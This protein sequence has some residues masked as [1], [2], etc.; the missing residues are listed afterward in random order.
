MREFFE[1]WKPSRKS[2]WLIIQINEILDDYES[3][4]YQLTLR[5]LYYQLVSRDLGVAVKQVVKLW[6]REEISGENRDKIIG[7]LLEK[8][9]EEEIRNRV[10]NFL[11][12]ET[13]KTVNAILEEAINR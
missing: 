9:V 4:G 1:E 8:R 13:Q 2:S 5:Q 7:L 12:D 10:N 11:M 3:Q 6:L